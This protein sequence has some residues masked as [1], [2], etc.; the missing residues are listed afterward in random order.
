MVKFQ[1]E[2]QNYVTSLFFTNSH[3]YNYLLCGRYKINQFNA[4][5][6]AVLVTILDL[7]QLLFN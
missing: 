1:L 4:N 7:I 3:L 2:T 5:F 6:V